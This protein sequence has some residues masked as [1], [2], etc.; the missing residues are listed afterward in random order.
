MTSTR[1]PGKILK[2]ILGKSLLELLIERVKKTRDI[3][4]IV[5]ASPLGAEHAPI[6]RIALNTEVTFIRGDEHD[7]LSRFQDAAEATNADI[8]IRITSDCPLYDFKIMSSWIA[9][10]LH[11]ELSYLHSSFERG[12]PLGLTAEI[13]TRSAL[14][15][16]FQKAEDIYERE[17]VTPYIWRRPE[18]FP[19]LYLEYAPNLHEW[20]FAVD[21]TPDFEFV[22]TVFESLYPT[23]PDFCFKDIK[24]L[25]ESN[26]K[27]LNINQHVQQKPLIYLGEQNG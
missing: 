7:V 2:Q 17:H 22:K 4:E 23:N 13:L 10:F 3:D 12:Y 15:Q 8:I 14:E 24:N 11:S 5:I 20:R 18:L 27:L 16:A 25:L 1:L 26:P 6:E 19:A 9:L 21:E